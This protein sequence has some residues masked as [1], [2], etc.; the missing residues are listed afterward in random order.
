MP[1]YSHS[2]L[3]RSDPSRIGPPGQLV[4]FGT[5]ASGV[6]FIKRYSQVKES[7]PWVSCASGNVFMKSPIFWCMR[8]GLGN[9]PQFGAPPSLFCARPLYPQE[10]LKVPIGVNNNLIKCS[11]VHKCLGSL[12]SV[13]YKI[14]R[15]LTHCIIE[16]PSEWMSVE[17][18]LWAVLRLFLLINQSHHQKYYFKIKQIKA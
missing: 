10:V 15:S 14:K 8:L 2:L 6:L 18:T 1:A 5:I 16:S 12:W 17:V 3:C 11:E 9:P 4:K 7:I 13:C